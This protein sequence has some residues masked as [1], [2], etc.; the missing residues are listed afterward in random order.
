[1]KKITFFL[2][3][4]F[5]FQFCKEKE[6][7]APR[8]PLESSFIMNFP[9]TINITK[10]KDNS[11]SRFV[12]E[13]LN[14]WSTIICDSLIVVKESYCEALK[15]ENAIYL[16][17]NTWLQT[18]YF[19]L[20]EA[21]FIGKL[22]IKTEN[23]SLDIKMYLSKAGEYENFLWFKGYCDINLTAGS[24]T[25]LDKPPIANYEPQELLLIEWDNTNKNKYLIKYTNIESDSTVNGNYISYDFV[26]NNNFTN[27]YN[28]Y[29]KELNDS[30]NIEINKNTRE[31]RVKNF[32]QFS[33]EEWH[34][35]NEFF[36]NTECE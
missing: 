26:S 9:N 5:F 16:K 1:M 35:W 4:L 19:E 18:F 29:D 28:I 6:K 36:E 23:D 13:E 31:G 21:D 17:E 15:K 12:F 8:L 20:G 33:D 10:Y 25:L 30:T 34:C 22:Y 27:I 3:I 24:W 14:V 2:M 7:T 32:I 11:N